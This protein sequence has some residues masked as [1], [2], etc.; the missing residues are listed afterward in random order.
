MQ[1]NLLPLNNRFKRQELNNKS[2]RE[3]DYFGVFRLK[4]T[5]VFESYVSVLF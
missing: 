4:G 1:Y 2:E 5:T 3:N